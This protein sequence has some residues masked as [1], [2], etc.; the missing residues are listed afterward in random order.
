MVGLT[1]AA[2]TAAGDPTIG[3]VVVTAQ[4]RSE[5]LE[6]VPMS[7]TAV[8]PQ[9]LERSGVGN[10]LDLGRVTPGAQVNFAGVFVQPA[11]RGITTLTNGNNVEN[12]VAIYVDGFY[13]ASGLI[14]NMELAN[15]ADIEVLK[16]PQGTLYGRNAT[17]GAILINTLAPSKV[18]TGDVQATYAR[19]NDRR[20]SAYISG[21][22]TDRVRASLSGYWNRSDGYIKKADPADTS[23]TSGDAAPLDREALRLKVEADVTSD[24]T[25]TVGLNYTQMN[26][27]RGNLFSGFT[28]ILPITPPSARAPRLGT[29]AFNGENKNLA[30]NKQATLKLAYNTPIGT[31]TSYTGFTHG[32]TRSAFDFDGTYVDI[33][34]FRSGFR[35]EN[36]QQAVDYQIT[37]IDHLDL[38]IGGLFYHDWIET[39]P[40]TQ[41]FANGVVASQT[42]F[43][44]WTKAW[45]GYID[46]TYHFTDQLSLNLGGRYSSETRK[47]LFVPLTGT[48]AIVA[49]FTGHEKYQET[50][51]KFTPRASI[52]YEIEPRTSVYAS[53]SQGFRPGIFNGSGSADPR[54][55]APTR[56]ET[57]T[58]Y[59]VGF[60]TARSRLRFDAAAFYYDY[61]DLNLSVTAPNPFCPPGAICG[62]ATIF[63][64]AK[65]AEVYGLDTQLTLNP[66]DNLNVRIGAAWLHARYKDAANATGTGVNASNTLNV[67]GEAQDWSGQQMSRAPNFSANLGADYTIDNVLNGTLLLSGN[68]SYTD[69]YVVSN[70]SL[71]GPLFPAAANVQ[72]FRQ[73]AYSIVNLSATWRDASNHYSITAFGNNI[74]DKLYR[75][76]YSGSVFS[77]LVVPGDPA[78]YGVRVRYEF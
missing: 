49:P 34:R 72:R 13:E 44:Q 69:S 7:I 64:N 35:Q 26:D 19:F 5:R 42:Y 57:I 54:L 36:W 41:Q 61:K 65:K 16:G 46:A 76:T 43:Q 12:N 63:G 32:L 48:G 10:L 52:R 38:V 6:S 68:Y 29:A 28:R 15:I 71:Y 11:I 66:I 73:P 74:F 22:I 40:T 75:N 31:L 50:F 56:S 14:I 25:A 59:E 58:A 27:P 45:A 60:K 53:V 24:L 55:I 23:R 67:P 37:A 18:L 1:A 21:P 47:F 3:E 2:Q 9:T 62:L 33:S 8:T 30:I 51:N 4:R 39:Y 70:P 20:F 77:D 78:T 17:G